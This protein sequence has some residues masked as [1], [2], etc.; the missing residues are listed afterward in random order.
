MN[1]AGRKLKANLRR[2][3]G[4]AKGKS[5]FYKMETIARKKARRNSLARRFS[6]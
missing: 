3:Y 2:E 1:A 4:T 5:V 6:K